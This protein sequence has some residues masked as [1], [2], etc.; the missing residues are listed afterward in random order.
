MLRGLT[1][2]ASD[3]EASLA[4]LLDEHLATPDLA[5]ALGLETVEVPRA[6]LERALLRPAANMLARPGKRFRARLVELGATL[7]GGAAPLPPLLPALIELIHA[8]SLVVDDIQDGSAIRR[9]QPA[10]HRLY[11]VPLALNA[12]NWLYFWPLELLSALDLPA[13]RELALH[14]AV[15][16]AIYR[17][18]FGQALDLGLRIGTLRQNEL[19]ELVGAISELKTGA[20]MELAASIGALA[21]GA[22]PTHV[23]ALARFGRQ[24]GIAFQ[25]L[26]DVANLD[27]A[28][29]P[30]KRHEDLRLGRATWVWAWLARRLEPERFR[31]L[32]HRA[33]A[34]AHGTLELPSL[35]RA[36]AMHLEGH[37]RHAAESLLA[38]A[39]DELAGALGPHAALEALE[40]EITQLVGRHG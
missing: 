1:K 35:A 22:H 13:E 31:V 27:G 16:R 8:G 38:R 29:D 30:D 33:R 23:Q 28:G 39:C 4:G 34:L 12:G 10:L 32:Q 19:P 18:H 37:G 24:A 36:L 15:T 17:C 14:R 11:G 40:R 20:F 2:D 6:A 25:M 3:T 26:D 21:T 9:Q 7:G 5:A